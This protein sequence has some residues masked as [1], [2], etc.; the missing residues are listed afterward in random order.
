MGWAT[1]VIVP[2]DGNMDEYILSLKKLLLYDYNIYYPTHGSPIENPKKYVRG[3]IAHRKMREVQILEEL[4]KNSLCIDEM[5]LN[6]MQLQ[7][8][9]YGRLLQC[10]YLLLC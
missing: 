10:H 9:D 3:L 8:K 6:F 5:I 4:K 2:P 1:T 7:I